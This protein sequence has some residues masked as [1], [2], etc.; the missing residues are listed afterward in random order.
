MAIRW[1]NYRVG[2]FYDELIRVANKPRPAAEQICK[3]LR[4]LSDKELEE[5]KTAASTAIHVMGITFT[6]YS[7]EEGSIDRAWPFDIIPRIIDKKEWLEVEKGLKQRVK[8]LNMFIDDLYNE[9][10]ILEAGVV[11]K[12]LLEASKNFLPECKGVK[13]K[14]GVWAHIGVLRPSP[15]N[16]H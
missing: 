9:Q 4:N 2:D 8:A 7:E 12:S 14:N 6:V 3:Y 13:P 15:R 1:G 11:P 16:R 10:R 5:Y